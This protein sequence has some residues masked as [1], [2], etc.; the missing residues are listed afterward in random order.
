MLVAAWLPRIQEIMG[1]GMRCCG[2]ESLGISI[3]VA[4]CDPLNR[5]VS[6]PAARDSLFTLLPKDKSFQI[7]LLILLILIILPISSFFFCSIA[8][9]TLILQLV[10]R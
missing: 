9:L 5:P 1:V 3:V 6:R 7:V 2:R 4:N 10:A 8:L